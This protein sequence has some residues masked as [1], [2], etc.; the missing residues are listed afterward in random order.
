MNSPDMAKKK[1]KTAKVKNE[2]SERSAQLYAYVEAP[3][4]G[5]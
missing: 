5:V 4:Y 1:R 2:T 3:S